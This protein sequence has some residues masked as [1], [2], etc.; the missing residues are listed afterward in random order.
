MITPVGRLTDDAAIAAV[1][2]ASEVWRHLKWNI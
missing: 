2:I 1:K